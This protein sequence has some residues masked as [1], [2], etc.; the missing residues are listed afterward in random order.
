MASGI[1]GVSTD[2][3]GVKDVIATTDL[4]ARAPYGDA[5]ALAAAVVR[6]LADATLRRETGAR[7]RT[8]VL[9]RYSLDRLINDIIALYRGRVAA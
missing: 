6:Y 5:G 7:A 3:G 2:V 1:P 8:A 4:G 9:D